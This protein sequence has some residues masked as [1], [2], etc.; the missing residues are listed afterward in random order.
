MARVIFLVACIDLMRPLRIRSCPP[1]ISDHSVARVLSD[2][3]SPTSPASTLVETGTFKPDEV[4]LPGIY[5]HRIVLNQRPEKRIEKRTITEK[6]G[7]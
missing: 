4:H 5:V 2:A 1:A 6:A 7:V 3:A